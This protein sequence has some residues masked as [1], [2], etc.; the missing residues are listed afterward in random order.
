MP[1]QPDPL[2]QIFRRYLKDG[3]MQAPC[4]CHALHGSS[5]HWIWHPQVSFACYIAWFLGSDVPWVG[6]HSTHFSTLAYLGWIVLPG[7]ATSEHYSCTFAISIPCLSPPSGG[8]WLPGIMHQLTRTI[9][10]LLHVFTFHLVGFI[11][12]RTRTW[13]EELVSPTQGF[14]GFVR[15]IRLSYSPSVC[16]SRSTGC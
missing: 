14:I 15:R 3:L 5:R 13:A 1:Y 6:L 12:V 11:S 9:V 7:T 16:M 4:P 8:I 10:C 2:G